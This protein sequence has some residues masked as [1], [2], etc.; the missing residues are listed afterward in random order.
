ML[1]WQSEESA[2][3][4]EKMNRVEY[5]F[6]SFFVQHSHKKILSILIFGCAMSSSKEANEALTVEIAPSLRL[7]G[8]WL[9]SDNGY[10]RTNFPNFFSWKYHMQAST[11]SSFLQAPP[12]QA[13]TS[14][15]THTSCHSHAASHSA[16][17]RTDGSVII[18]Y[19]PFY[20]CSAPF[21]NNPSYSICLTH[22]FF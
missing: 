18:L 14:Q 5:D 16:H 1:N 7:P 8:L 15:P 10:E 2:H 20:F 21:I 22:F 11:M 3:K 19:W 4:V 9:V 13:Q 17:Q 12:S 6:L